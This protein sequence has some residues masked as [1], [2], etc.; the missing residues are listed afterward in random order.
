MFKAKPKQKSKVLS[1]QKI[2][3]HKVIFTFESTDAKDIVLMGDFNN[4][5]P[6]KHPMNNSGNSSWK[7]AVMLSPGRYEYKFFVDGKWKEDPR[8]AQTCR[9]C[10][11]TLNSVLEVTER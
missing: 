10:F 8:N 1:K 9:N 3:R 2:G 11:G 7:K 4:W 5:N 6:K